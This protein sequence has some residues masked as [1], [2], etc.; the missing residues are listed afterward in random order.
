MKSQTQDS[1]CVYRHTTPN[2][3][4]YFGITSY[5]PIDRWTSTGSGYNK[6]V[7]GAAVRKYGWNNIAH[8]ILNFDSSGDLQWIEYTPGLDIGLTNIFCEEDAKE[9][10][11]ALIRKY[12]TYLKANGYNKT[13]GGEAELPT[14][15]TRKRTSESHLRMWADDDYRAN[16]SGRNSPFW[17]DYDKIIFKL[18]DKKPNATLY[19]LANQAG[20]CIN[21]AIHFRKE[22]LSL[23]PGA[24]IAVDRS[25]DNNPNYRKMDKKIF[26][27][28]DSHPTATAPQ[29]QQA[30]GCNECTAL[31]YRKQWKQVRGI[32]PRPSFREQIFALMNSNPEIMLKDIM[33]ATGCS[34]LT[35]SKYRKQWQ[36]DHP[37]IE[38]RRSQ[39]GKYNPNYKG[40]DKRIFSY[41]DLHPTASLNDICKAISCSDK[42]AIK[43]RRQWQ[44]LS[45]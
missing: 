30:T 38:S 7:F 23:H 13:F 20:C 22:W 10:E 29:I 6:Q 11:Q 1:W 42:T 2:N 34:E 31:K 15:E 45:I 8:H 12:K 5:P 21:T 41:L 24:S 27:F 35:A 17:K 3:K 18:L 39:D 37:E 9:Y 44:T 36:A 33:L 26:N 28:L 25:G 19:Q 32:K 40:V 43:Y 16:R 14:E 4:I